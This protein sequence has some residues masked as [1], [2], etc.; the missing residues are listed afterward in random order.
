MRVFC[1]VESYRTEQPAHGTID[2][3]L[4]HAGSTGK[5]KSR[6]DFNACCAFVEGVIER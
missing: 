6:I 4:D 3:G 2:A 1:G 5:S